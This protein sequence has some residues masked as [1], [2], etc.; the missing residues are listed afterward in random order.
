MLEV[1]VMYLYVRGIDLA[2]ISTIFLLNFRKMKMN[3]GLN[4]VVDAML[5]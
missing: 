4:P 3:M 5:L 2:S 1:P